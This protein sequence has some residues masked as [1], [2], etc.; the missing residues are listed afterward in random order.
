MSSTIDVD[1]LWARMNAPI[2]DIQLPVVSNENAR[3]G[4]SENRSNPPRHLPEEE[5]ITINRVY[6]FAGE[7]ITEKKA[8]PK[9]SAEAKLHLASE[10]LKKAPDLTTIRRNENGLPLRR[11]VRRYSRFDPNPPDTIK[12]NWEKRASEEDKGTKGPRLNTIIKSKLD[13]AAY[14]D[15]AGIKDDLDTHSRAKEGYLERMD[16]LNRVDAKQEEERRNARLKSQQAF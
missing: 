12:K 3:G 6:K 8:V 7:V 11:P 4:K 1:A 5:T 15:R 14:V 9:D 10:D 2:T 16:F 13:W